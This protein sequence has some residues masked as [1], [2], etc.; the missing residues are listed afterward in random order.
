MKLD[1]TQELIDPATGEPIKRHR[2]DP[3]NPNVYERGPDRLPIIETL[4]LRVICQEALR[5][6]ALSGDQ[7]KAV[8]R[9]E[10]LGKF[11][12]D[13]VELTGT[14]INL[15]CD[16]IAGYYSFPLYSG[17]ALQLLRAYERAIAPQPKAPGKAGK[18][19]P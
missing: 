14:E 16:A 6:G 13:E 8:H 2:P 1:V 4:T 17:P 5:Y 12:E 7:V 9:V 10:V 15:V 19:K 3:A 11:R 18:L